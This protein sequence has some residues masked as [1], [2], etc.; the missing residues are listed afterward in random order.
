MKAVILGALAVAGFLML[1]AGLPNRGNQVWAQR[2]TPNTPTGFDGGLVAL[3]GGPTE[4]GQLVTVVD[5]RTRAMGVYRIEGATGKI[6]L[7]SV[8]NIQWDLQM[9]QLNSET[10]LPLEIRSLLEQK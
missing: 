5:S 7:L 9:M 4:G 8:R 3:P 1:A 2:A 10:P 6:K